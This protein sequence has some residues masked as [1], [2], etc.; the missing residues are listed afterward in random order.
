MRVTYT[1]LLAT[2][3]TVVGLPVFAEGKLQLTKMS[4][5]KWAPCDP[6]A[7]QP[8]PCQINY[9]RGNPEKEENYAF[10]KI[11]KGHT[12][13]PHW[14]TQNENIIV[15]QGTLIIGGEKDSK[16]TPVRAGEYGFVPAKWIHWATCADQDCV[17]YLNNE[18][19]D[20]Y[21]DVNER[22]PD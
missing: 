13:P 19:A 15:T 4:D 3:C 6:K 11:P 5:I 16:G 18:A 14:H 12:F 9:F 17:F 10:I 21:I 8:D 1:L 20:S 7:P 22:R 2:L